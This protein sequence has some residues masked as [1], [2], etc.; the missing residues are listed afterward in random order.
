[1]KYFHNFTIPVWQ[2]FFGNLLLLF[3]SLFYLIWWIVTFRPASAGGSAA[4]V[5]CIAIAFITGLAAIALVSAGINSLSPYAQSLPVRYILLGG[6][7]LFVVLLLVT[8]MAFQRPVTSEL[9]IIHIWTVLELSAVAVLSGTGRLG[10]GQAVTL[11]ALIGIAFIAGLI[12]YLLY[13][14]LGGMAG[15]WDGMVPLIMDA[16]VLTVFLGV[17]AVS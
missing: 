16:F 12:C 1:M 8:S 9:M 13:Y 2:I 7:V 11:A 3:C 10:P 6:T 14:R 15:Y 5:L 4:G 17:L